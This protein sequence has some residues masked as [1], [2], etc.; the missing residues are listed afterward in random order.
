[1]EK[2]QAGLRSVVRLLIF[3]VYI[4]IFLIS[5]YAIHFATRDPLKRRRRFSVN[6]VFWTRL[7]CKTFRIKVL[8]KGD[9]KPDQVGLVVGN[10]LGFIDII[11]SASIRPNLFVTSEEMHKTPF[12]GLLTEMGGCIYVNRLSRSGILRELGEMA[13]YL[14]AGFRVILYPEAMATNGE[15]ILPFKRTLLTAAAHAN[16]PI[17][18]YVFNFREIN[19]EP[20]FPMKYRDSVCW[21]GDIPFHVAIWRAFSLKSLVCEVEFLSPVYT[22]TDQDRAAVA[23]AI[24]EQIL[25]KYTPVAPSSSAP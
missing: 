21:Y 1:M 10:H 25:E 12:L 18:P 13:E 15:G 24:R 6:G 9:P 22:R 14:K 2:I 3:A 11:A 4:V 16:V 17:L 8:V 20:G 5:A 19:G 23:D 7:V